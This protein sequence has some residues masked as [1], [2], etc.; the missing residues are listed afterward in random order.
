MKTGFRFLIASSCC[1]GVAVIASGCTVTTGDD[2]GPTQVVDTVDVYDTCGSDIDCPSDTACFTT[3]V[4]YEDGSVTDSS[5]TVEC[6]SDFDCPFDGS[7]QGADVGPPLCYQ[8]CEADADCPIGF[9]CVADVFV[10]PSDP[11]CVP[12]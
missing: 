6:S 10:S 2:G 9:G 11:V 4:E 1:L 5:C 7:C 12:F 8:R 3:T